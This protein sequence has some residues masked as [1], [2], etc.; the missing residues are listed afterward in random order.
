MAKVRA[1]QATGAATRRRRGRVLLRGESVNASSGLIVAAIVTFVT[2][3]TAWWSAGGAA[4]LGLTGDPVI[5]ACVVGGQGLTMVWAWYRWRRRRLRALGAIR[6]ALAAYGAGETDD[7]ALRLAASFGPAGE[8]WNR[9]LEERRELAERLRTQR[10]SDELSA[11]HARGGDTQVLCDALWQGLLLVDDKMTVRYANGAAAVL[12]QARREQMVNAE[13]ARVISDR[14]VLAAIRDVAAG[15]SKPRGALEVRRGP[16]G[17]AVTGG[18]GGAEPQGVLRFH[19]RPIRRNDAGAALVVI[20]DVT[21][22]RAADEARNAFVAQAAHELRTPLT[23]IRLNVEQIV[24]EGEND[25]AARAECINVIGREARRLER[26]V[27]DMLS[28]SEVE[29]GALSLRTDDVRLD[30]LMKELEEEFRAPALDKDMKLRFDLPPKLPVI[31]GDRDKIVL[32][33]HNVI[34]NAIKYTPAGGEVSVKVVEDGPGVVIEVADNGIGI[35]ED[36]IEM[37]FEKFYRAK[38][39]RV[40]SITGT[41]LGLALARQVVRLHGGDITVKS[42]LD[43]GST[44]TIAI[45]A[46]AGEKRQAA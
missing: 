41:G 46:V 43:K 12:L 39:R 5:G 20:E 4:R 3:G 44:F 30:A 6:E 24:D 8:A 7:A 32:A 25:P 2:L 38:D 1:E 18:T 13:A 23:G 14:Q 10:V 16:G 33:V 28:L 40:A 26:I 27:G 42:H 19:V 29:S 9:L 45:P 36:E 31:Q 35:K 15:R 17:A 37:V 21:Q 22:Q 34:A 11:R